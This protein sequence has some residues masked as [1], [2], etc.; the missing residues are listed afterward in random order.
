MSSKRKRQTRVEFISSRSTTPNPSTITLPTARSV[1]FSR[2]STGR[3]GETSDSVEVPI[4]AE[5]LIILQEHPEFSVPAESYLDFESSVHDALQ[6]TESAVRDDD[7]DS[8]TASTRVHSSSCSRPYR[9][10]VHVF[11]RLIPM[12]NGYRSAKTSWTK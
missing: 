12:G 4:S 1:T 2:Q 3:L 10:F 8:E 6:G 9:V 5:D 7:G 11:K